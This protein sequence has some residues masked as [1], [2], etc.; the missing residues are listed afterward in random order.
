MK[1]FLIVF[2]VLVGLL[3]AVYFYFFQLSP[4]E[5]NNPMNAVPASAA[6][7]ISMEEPLAQWK[8]LT[9]NEIWEYLKSNPVLAS[10][11]QSVDSLNA[12]IKKNE[13]L[14]SLVANRPIV[15][16][17][18]P[19]SSNKYDFLVT[20]DLQKATQLG[21]L[22]NYLDKF[23]GDEAKI[24]NRKYLDSEIIEFSYY[25]DPEIY[26]LSL[27]DNLLLF[28][29][30]HTLIE[31]SI[32]QKS[33]P[34][35]ARDL[36]FVEISKYM[37]VNSPTIYFHQ[38]NFK[39][40]LE[41]FTSSEAQKENLQFLTYSDYVGLNLA[42]GDDYISVHGYSDEPDSK[43][44]MVQALLKTGKGEINL[45]AIVPENAS[46]FTS[47][48]FSDARSFY[49]N[50]E[51]I[52]K[53]DESEGEYESNKERLEKFLDISIEENIIS[54]ID[55]EIGLIQLNSSSNRNSIELAVAI[56][57]ND[58]DDLNENLDYIEKKIRRKTPVKFK[59]IDYKGYQIKF[60][61]IKGLF[62]LVFGKMFSSIEKPYYVI[63]EDYIVFSNSPK[64]LGKIITATV[65]NKTLNSTKEYAEFMEEFKH[66]SNL[67]LYVSAQELLTDAKNVMD[68]ESWAALSKHKKYIEGFPLL[69]IQLLPE[70]DLLAY[71][72]QM[73]H[74]NNI[75]QDNW[76]SLLQE[77]SLATEQDT[78]EEDAMEDDY[79]IAVENILPED[80][81]DKK[82]TQEFD[83]GQLKFEVSLKDGLKHGRYSEYD[84]LGNLIIK[85]RYKEDKKVG[86]WKFYDSEGNL[87]KKIKE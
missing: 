11:G 64:T 36:N 15:L 1:K 58:V 55:N 23:I 37:E 70:N 81:N 12:E 67:F 87:V 61:S 46:A 29:T 47:L 4:V 40:F 86:T 31:E 25:D 24:F 13:G 2:V 76:K 8:E 35:I 63:L 75:E 16:S 21:F 56:R 17:Y 54:W 72:L 14:W 71:R 32:K 18:H 39:T 26:Y 28:S 77:L 60:L 62:K 50:L 9:N 69:G 59:G 27:V 3:G 10:I 52:L 33:K 6:L 66:E 84:S 45:G 79:I 57:Y 44:N 73:K 74:L 68:N 19:V 83:N 30:T 78:A 53:N 41:K 49:A 34:L 43:P 42:V 82:L 85:G 65:E 80:L 7:I 38:K 22:K 48:G 51:N 20:C 5:K